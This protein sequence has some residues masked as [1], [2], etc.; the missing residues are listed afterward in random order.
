MQT[1]APQNAAY[2]HDDSFKMMRKGGEIKSSSYSTFRK[3]MS[4]Q[5][6]PPTAAESKHSSTPSYGDDSEASTSEDDESVGSL[7]EFVTGDSSDEEDHPQASAA[8]QK[9]RRVIEVPPSEDD[10]SSYASDEVPSDVEP[11][12]REPTK[13]GK[14]SVRARPLAPVERY[15]DA[16]NHAAACRREGFMPYGAPARRPRMVPDDARGPPRDDAPRPRSRKSAPLPVQSPRGE[17]QPSKRKRPYAC[18][19]HAQSSGAAG[20][21]GGAAASSESYTSSSYP[22]ATY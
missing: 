17:G 19:V 15:W 14:Y 18:D 11:P 13:A 6:V 8:P 12:R 5:S 10:A 16:R 22:N 4:Q 21:G 9:R 2:V 3:Q 20:G 7:A 1:T